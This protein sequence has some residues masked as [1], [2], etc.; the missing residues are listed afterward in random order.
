MSGRVSPSAFV[1]FP[2]LA[3]FATVAPPRARGAASD[4]CSRDPGRPA[5]VRVDACVRKFAGKP[6]VVHHGEPL[7]LR[8][9]HPNVFRESYELQLQGSDVHSTGIPDALKGLIFV[10]NGSVGPLP[11]FAR[12]PEINPME[13]KAVLGD[14]PTRFNGVQDSLKEIRD[15]LNTPGWKRV[16]EP[17]TARLWS[18]MINA[19]DDSTARCGALDSIS[20]VADSWVGDPTLARSYSA[21]RQVPHFTPESA[22]VLITD[23]GRL[24]P[25][26]AMRTAALIKPGSQS[27]SDWNESYMSWRLLHPGD[28]KPEAE[29]PIEANEQVQSGK[30]WLDAQVTRFDGARAELETFVMLAA[31]ALDPLR[32]PDSLQRVVKV[33]GDEVI[34][35]VVFRPREPTDKEKTLPRVPEFNLTT[36]IPGTHRWAFTVS[37]GVGVTDLLQ[38]NY[39]T[40]P[41]PDSNQT[42]I[43]KR[44]VRDEA[45]VVAV[46]QAQLLYTERLGSMAWG[47]GPAVGIAP[48]SP[49]RY[50]LGGSIEFGSRVRLLLSGGAAWGQVGVLNGERVDQPLVNAIDLKMVMRRGSYGSLT[51][52]IAFMP[53]PAASAGK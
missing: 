49:A 4:D 35:T 53:P 45:A 29:W 17:I 18:A 10:A 41:P 27:I 46:T 39:F 50:L 42:R 14:L 44:G 37:A 6:C 51:F 31:A 20:A 11:N 43:V 33:D 5:V 3:L 28:R 48:A 16:G 52:S 32:C 30:K 25:R 22:R 2:I 40:A 34:A 13:I 26:F 8:V 19:P 9:L 7:T 36:R 15:A 24:V 23:L 38:S 1:L 47:W 12:A 21:A